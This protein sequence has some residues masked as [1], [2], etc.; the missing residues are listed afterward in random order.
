MSAMRTHYSIFAVAQQSSKIHINNLEADQ[1]WCSRLE[2]IT[3]RAGPNNSLD[4]LLIRPIQ[5]ICRYPLLFEHLS[6]EAS[7]LDQGNAEELQDL[8]NRSVRMVDY[9]N[10]LSRASENQRKIANLSKRLIGFNLSFSLLGENLVV[11]RKIKLWE[12]RLSA[13]NEATTLH[14]VLFSKYLLLSIETKEK[15]RSWRSAESLE[16]RTNRHRTPDDSSRLK[17][18]F[19]IELAVSSIYPNP[20]IVGNDEI[21]FWIDHE[22]TR[23]ILPFASL[24]LVRP[25]D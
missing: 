22:G 21:H 12:P 16:K 1:T 5:R 13:S 8:Q 7:K 2:A 3:A 15:K 14:A 10:S 9:V 25:C 4:S 20:I 17:C 23:C 19:L 11:E 6:T 24:F 18:K